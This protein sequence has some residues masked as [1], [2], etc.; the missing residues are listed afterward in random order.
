[1]KFGS[2]QKKIISLTHNKIVLY[3]LLA[4][5]LF[6]L[7]SY[8]GQN[9]LGAI[10]LFLIIGFGSTCYTKNMVLVLLM[11]IFATSLLLNMGFLKLFVMREGFDS[12]S[13]N[14]MGSPPN[15]GM[16]SPPNNG[17]GSSSNN[18]MGSSSNNGM[19]SSSNNGMGSSSNNGMGSSNP[20]GDVA[21]L[22]R[23]VN[24][25]AGSNMNPLTPAPVPDMSQMSSQVDKIGVET[26][27]LKTKTAE[28]QSTT[29]ALADLVNQAKQLMARVSTTSS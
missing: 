24:S 9:N 8:L 19:G 7:M 10:V 14:G 23:N 22:A 26:D 12:T 25:G 20:P 17:M 3:I 11:A 1:M 28:A 4:F 13:N 5:A 18:G 29:N 27:K 2:I 6:N 16:G 15:N 21:N